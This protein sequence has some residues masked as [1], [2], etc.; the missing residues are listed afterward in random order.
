MVKGLKTALGDGYG[1]FKAT[2]VA[3][4]TGAVDARAFYD[5]ASRLLMRHHPDLLL[6]VLRTLP[7]EAKRDQALGLHAA[8]C[9]PRCDTPIDGI[10]R[11]RHSAGS[12]GGRTG[13]VALGLQRNAHR[14]AVEKPSHGAGVSSGGVG[15]V[16]QA[17]GATAFAFKAGGVERDR[18]TKSEVL[19]PGLVCIRRAIG[20]EMQA[21]LA[22][23][24]FKVGESGGEGTGK[25]GFYDTV[26][27]EKPGQAPTLRL[28]Q[29][30]RGRVILGIEEFP[31]KLRQLC[32]DCV[33]AAQKVDPANMPTLNPTTVLVNFYKEGA[34]F[35]WHRDSEDPALSRTNTAPPIVSFTVG[36]SADFAYKRHFEEE[37]YETVRLN[38]GDVLLFGGPA[39]MIVHSVTRVIPKTM[40]GMMRGKMLHGR[41]N[42]TIR[43]IGRG[44]I[45]TSMF[46]AYRVSYD[47]VVSSDK[48]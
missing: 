17:G 32:M 18:G 38:S 33:A 43:D 6:E 39:R 36:L 9:M 29:G 41:L 8:A 30:T 21:W 15:G 26:P 10:P 27:P 24:A 31:E 34:Q 16:Y 40:P 13:D 37:H 28:N 22:D 42:I 44:V 12:R 14:D 19:A 48:V 25:F 23:T 3:F 5:T 11:P 47:N 7:D 35:K 45:D 1:D 20:Y 2:S 4:Q 46:P